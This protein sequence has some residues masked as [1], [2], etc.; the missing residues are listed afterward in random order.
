MDREDFLNKKIKMLMQEGGYTKPQAQA[1]SK[2]DLQQIELPDLGGSN[3]VAQG[4]KKIKNIQRG[5]TKNG[6]EG[7]Y[8]YYDKTP[9]EPGFDPEIH[10]DWVFSKSIME[11]TNKETPALYNQHLYNYKKETGNY[12][13]GGGINLEAQFMSPQQDFSKPL[14][15]PYDPYAWLKSLPNTNYDQNY[16]GM[17]TEQEQLMPLSPQEQQ[18]SVTG[19]GTADRTSEDASKP[20]LIGG[21]EQNIN[22]RF[23]I[24][25]N[26]GGIGLEDA[27]TY[28]GQAFGNK[29][30]GK[31][32]MGAGLSLLKGSRNFLTGYASGKENNR[33]KNEYMDK[34]FN[35]DPNFKAFQQ[36]GVLSN[37]EY[38]T[39]QFVA[40]EGQGN[41]NVENKEFIKR[42]DTGNVQQVVGEPHVKNGKIADGVDVNLNQGDKVLSTYVKIPP[43]DVKE[44]KQRYDISLRKGA[45]F[46]DAQKA[47]DK[48]IGITKLTDE[49]AEYIEK[50]GKNDSVEDATTKRL[51]EIA[52]T[53]KTN[54]VQEKLTTLKNP[55]SMVFEDLF[56]RQEVIPKKGKP[57]E[58]LDKNGKPLEEKE[59]DA[60]QQGGIAELAKKHGI[61]IER[62]NELVQMQ[63][64]GE[65]G[66]DQMQQVFEAIAQM[67]QQGMQ[68]EEVA[69]Q[70]VQMGVPQEQVGELINQ[71]MQGGMAQQGGE[72]DQVFQ[73]VQEMLEQGMQPE[74]VA[75]QLLQMGVPEEQIGQ[76]IQQVMQPQ[77]AQQGIPTYDINTRLN[78][79]ISGYEVTGQP[80]VDKD[81]LTG[82]EWIQPYKEGVGYGAQMVSPEETVK[83]HDWYF[84]TKEKRDKF[85]EASKKQGRQPEIEAY[86]KAYNEELKKRGTDSGMSEQETDNLIETT[87]FSDKGVQKLDGL[88]GAFTSSRPLWKKDLKVPEAEQVQAEVVVDP[89]TGERTVKGNIEKTTDVLPWLPQKLS[90]FPSSLD[91]IA[92]EQI[93]LN[94]IDPVKTTPESMLQNQ[95]SLR[96]TDVARVQ[97]SGLTPLQ[98][99]ALMASGLATSQISGNDAISKAEQYNAQNQFAVDQFNIGQGSKEDITNA[100][101]RSKYQD[102]VMGSLANQERDMRNFYTDNY[103]DQASK[104]K[105]IDEMNWLNAKNSNYQNVPGKGITYLNNQAQNFSNAA[106]EEKIAKLTPEQE[107]KFKKRVSTGM[108]REEALALSMV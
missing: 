28:T 17:T 6:K 63:E 18:Y 101:F 42:A 54:K 100:Q 40:D 55:Q 43:K 7:V 97:A 91:P 31:G 67:L 36:G 61:S 34:R 20:S 47:F 10:R 51:N 107:L 95:E 24:L 45:T 79:T 19:L 1:I 81:M 30:Y 103:L 58:I 4:F 66:Q 93:Y 59:E 44:L 41:V 89:V 9:G 46:A 78:P 88:F 14:N 83:L 37:A 16:M 53:Q 71:V 68:P 86:Q 105:Y 65:Q 69:Q 12:Y 2:Y 76:I 23:N 39:G 22:E 99:E 60:A 29:E 90:L 85:I 38:L 64:G 27:L 73:A 52:L 57:G 26:Y 5:I 72:Q 108:G 92:K 11:Q 70:L 13:Q 50:I 96:Q 102:Q 21:D 8:Y 75:Q 74:E 32:A 82:V 3:E 77:V 104:F 35:T 48:K 87:G 98:Q 56:S 84:D 15:T 25:N 33:V 80:I 62:A 49:L 94:R 106:L